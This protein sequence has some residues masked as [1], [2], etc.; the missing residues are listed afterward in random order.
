MCQY[1][2]KRY[3]YCKSKHIGW[4]LVWCLAAKSAGAP[5]ENPEKDDRIINSSK[6]EARVA[7]NQN[8][9]NCPVCEGI[10]EEANE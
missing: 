6:G 1:R 2:R 10:E 8:N 5:C 3:K 7:F 4:T 9:P